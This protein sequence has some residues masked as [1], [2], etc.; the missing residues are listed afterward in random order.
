M[1]SF[2]DLIFPKTC[3][4]CHRT[5]QYF[6]SKCI[7]NLNTNHIR[8][9]YCHPFNASLSLFPYNSAIK[10]AIHD[11]KYNFV[12]DI[13]G[14]ISEI[15]LSNLNS[16]FPN[17][18][19]Y[20]QKENFVL[21]P[22]SLSDFRNNWRGFNQST[23][24]CQAFSQLSGLKFESDLLIRNRNNPPQVSM[25][26][27]IDRLTN[28]IDLFKISQDTIIP[29]NIIIFDD[30]CTTMSTLKSAARPIVDSGKISEIWALSLAGY[31]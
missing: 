13:V 22:I 7:N 1:I 5:G 29:Q 11:L 18:L 17:L 8:I 15:M 31:F 14:E 12:T 3:Y 30:V 27:K 24:I 20:W 9:N 10:D 16:S 2:L 25:S 21:V 23:L 28:S 26:K 19:H 4:S 6:C